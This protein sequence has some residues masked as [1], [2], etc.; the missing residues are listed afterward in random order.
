MRGRCGEHAAGAI[1]HG[2]HAGSV[3]LVANQFGG[4]VGTDEHG[5]VPWA[6]PLLTDRGARGQQP[7]DVGGH[8]AGNVL[9]GSSDRRQPSLAQVDPRRLSGH[10]AHSKRGVARRAA[11]PRPLVSG[12]GSDL[13]VDDVGMAKPRVGE[14]GIVGVEQRLI[15]APVLAQRGARPRGGGG[16]QVRVHVRAP[17]RIDRLLGVGYQ[18]ER[19]SLGRERAVED[20]PLDRVC[21]LKLVDEHDRVAAAQPLT[22]GRA[23][24]TAEDVIEPR[25]QVVVGHDR[26]PPLSLFELLPH[27]PGEAVAHRRRAV[28]GRAARLEIGHRLERGLPGDLQCLGTR[29]PR[30]L[31]PDGEAADIQVVE[32]LFQQVGDILDE[33][34]RRIEVTDGAQLGQHLLA[35]AV[36]GGDRARVEV[37]DRAGQTVAPELDLAWVA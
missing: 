20:L 35:E 6:N 8:I 28:L 32:R 13:A 10:N 12:N 34:G 22:R 33:G 3:Q 2:R 31:V 7:H 23:V 25:E 5:D 29:E 16:G 17:E 30:R 14:Q 1:D 9:A 15:A 36:R 21:V 18:H 4:A 24:R 37:G 19:D 11:Q 27:A 26:E